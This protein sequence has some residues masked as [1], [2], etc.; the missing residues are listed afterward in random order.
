[1]A[2]TSKKSTASK[3]LKTSIV[4]PLVSTFKASA[5]PQLSTV[6]GLEEC[7]SKSSKL[8]EAR[9]HRARGMGKPHSWNSAP[10]LQPPPWP[11]PLQAL[12]LLALQ[13]TTGVSSTGKARQLCGRPGNV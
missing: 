7:K 8:W 9:S 10:P 1:M 2:S 4:L 13:E 3:S 11:P 12:G 5:A 6:T